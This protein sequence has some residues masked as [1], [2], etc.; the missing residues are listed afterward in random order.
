MN[1]FDEGI[2]ARKKGKSYLSNPHKKG[3]IEREQWDY[4]YLN[5]QKEHINNSNEFVE[6]YV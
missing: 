6:R 5:Q 4:G 1:A 3:T 2:E